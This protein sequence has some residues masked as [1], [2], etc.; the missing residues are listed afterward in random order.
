MARISIRERNMAF[1]ELFI[2]LPFDRRGSPQA[3]CRIMISA[4]IHSLF[5]SFSL[6]LSPLMYTRTFIQNS[7][8]SLPSLSLFH[9]FLCYVLILTYQSSPLVFLCHFLNFQALILFSLFSSIYYLPHFLS[10]PFLSFS[11]SI[12]PLFG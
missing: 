4:R 11:P 10:F 2:L 7:L 9:I 6:F 12:P 8:L 5:Y 1:Q 3:T